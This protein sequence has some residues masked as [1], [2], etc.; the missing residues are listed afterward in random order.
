MRMVPRVVVT[1]LGVVAPN[2]IGKDAFWT[3]L[4]ECRSGV[5]TITLFDASQHPCRI[6]GEVQDFDPVTHLGAGINAKRLARQTQLALAATFQALADAGISR[7][8]LASEAAVPLVLGVSSSAIEVIEYGMERMLERG[9]GKVPSHIVHACQP[10]QAAS[11]V[12]QHIPLLTRSTTISSACAAGVDAIA[13]ATELIRSGRADV[14]ICGGADAP[15]NPLTFACLAKA[16][17]VSLRNETPERASRPFDLNRDSGII[18]EGAG[19]LILENLDHA[20]T[21]GATPYLEISGYATHVDTDLDISGSG[22]DST[23]LEC[24]ANAGRRP[25]HVDYICAHGPGH[26]V[27]DRIETLMIKTVFGPKAYQIPVSSIKGVMGNP[28]AAA[29][30]LQAIAC[31]MAMR[32]DII[33]PTANLDTPDP[34]CDLDYVPKIPRRMRSTCILINA[35]GLGGGNSCLLVERVS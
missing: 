21:R 10:H 4:L 16:G 26:P 33:P 13:F 18:S 1:G 34:D 3:S 15:I 19:I 31:S 8:T 32:H 17:L 23:I 12:S 29:G 14:A 5:K 6:A 2:G 11:I 28:L 22:L 24:L 30:A 35:H 20:R 7:D 9:P 27:L 25:S